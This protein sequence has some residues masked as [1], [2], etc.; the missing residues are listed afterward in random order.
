MPERSLYQWRARGPAIGRCLVLL[1]LLGGVACSTGPARQLAARQ[2]LSAEVVAGD[3]FLHRVFRN[4]ARGRRLHVYLEGDGTPWR[5]RY[6]L[7][8]DPSPQRPLMLELMLLDSA[9]AL[10]LGRPCYHRVADAHCEPLWWTWRRYSPEVVGS[11]DR[12]LQRYASAYD[13]LVLFGHSGGGALA[14]LLAAR[15]SDVT[16]VLTLAA[17]L[18][19]DAWAAAHGYTPLQG[20]LNPAREPPLP[21]SVWQLHVLGARDSNIT[22]AMIVPA[23]SRQRR[24][25]LVLVPGQDHSCC[26]AELWPQLLA[27]QAT[28]L[29]ASGRRP[30]RQ[31]GTTALAG[32]EE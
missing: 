26:W 24:A 12:A 6:E 1:L 21:A 29:S 17:N 23:V 31:P 7:A 14:M 9:P 32:Q 28:A 4:H 18:D 20:S 11:L 2:G 19:P 27:W 15:R 5:T 30:G 3:P 10:Y 8:M 22:P 25:R 13:E 16:A